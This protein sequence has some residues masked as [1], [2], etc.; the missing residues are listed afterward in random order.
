[1]IRLT[2]IVLEN[3]KNVGHGRIVLASP[4]FDPEQWS[5]D[6]VGIYGQN[7]SG[8]TS[9]IMALNVL[10][11]IWGTGRPPAFCGECVAVGKDSFVVAVD[12][13]AHDAAGEFPD[14]SFT[15]R[16]EVAVLSG[17]PSVVA[18]KLSYRSAAEPKPVLR[19]AFEQVADSDPGSVRPKVSWDALRALDRGVAT[20]LHVA[21]RLAR[22]DGRSLLFSEEFGQVLQAILSICHARLSEEGSLSKSACKAREEVLL[23]SVDIRSELVRFATEG[24]AVVS[25]GRQA[26]PTFNVLRIST[27]VGADKRHADSYLTVDISKPVMV[28]EEELA[29]LK[30]TVNT[31]GT[32]LGALV[33]G[34]TLGLKSLGRMLAD[35]GSTAEAIELI[36]S[37]GGVSVPLRAE[38]EGIKKLVS[39]LVLLID[40]YARPD[41]CVAIDEL[42]SGVFEFLLGEV[43]QVLQDHGRGQLVFTAHN[44]R[45]LETLA[46]TSLVFTTTNPAN[47]YVSFRGSKASNNLR[48]QYLRAINLGGQP[49]TIYAPT[50]KYEI[51]SAFYDASNCRDVAPPALRSEL[52]TAGEQPTFGSSR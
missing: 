48:S 8:K 18:E 10:K 36:A 28:N 2:A 13:V 20:D 1:M 32:V 19:T 9:V 38:S 41:V 47:R 46:K 11:S 16:V 43:L 29:V 23:P 14:C 5:A 4:G 42:D 15:Y 22:A 50:S 37:R 17:T 30:T 40:V 35:D 27:H 21:W 6:I 51:D 24:L 49:E 25:S 31:V 12:A 7:G 34:L 44:L 45:P 26:E 52:V 3:F 39:I 33:P